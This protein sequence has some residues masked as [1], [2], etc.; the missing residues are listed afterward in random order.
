M[1][2]VPKEAI[3]LLEASKRPVS[4]ELKNA[5]DMLCQ[6]FDAATTFCNMYEESLSILF[7]N[8][9]VRA[10]NS[11]GVESNTPTEILVDF[12]QYDTGRWDI[13]SYRNPRGCGTYAK[14]APLQRAIKELQRICLHP[15]PWFKT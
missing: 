1:A 10:V 15:D 8:P 11:A 13:V 5:L 9:V 6:I 12:H 4:F 7:K 3:T 2:W 14:G